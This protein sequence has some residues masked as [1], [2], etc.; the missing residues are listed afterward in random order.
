MVNSSRY[1]THQLKKTNK[2]MLKTSGQIVAQQKLLDINSQPFCELLAQSQGYSFERID[3]LC[4]SEEMEMMMSKILLLLTPQSLR[5]KMAKHQV[6]IPSNSWNLCSLNLDKNV[7]NKKRYLQALLGYVEALGFR[8]ISN[9]LFTEYDANEALYYFESHG[10]LVLIPPTSVRQNT[11]LLPLDLTLIYMPKSIKPDVVTATMVRLD[12]CG[13]WT[14]QEEEAFLNL[15][16][17]DE[18]LQDFDIEAKSIRLNFKNEVL[19]QGF[20]QML[21]RF[22]QFVPDGFDEDQ[23]YYLVP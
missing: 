22:G 16:L 10:K 20:I 21:D 11:N 17:C 12:W 3:I 7:I 14:E 9:D 18:M 5:E 6:I 1:N 4:S 15:F 8:M 19:L 2:V 13:L 23:I